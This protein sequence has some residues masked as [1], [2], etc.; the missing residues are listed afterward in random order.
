MNNCFEE[1]PTHTFL[2]ILG[3]CN[4][5]VH[6]HFAHDSRT[7]ENGSRLIDLACEKSL[8]ITNTMFQKRKGKLWTF[9]NPK[10]NR[11]QLD[12]ILVN[13]KWKNSVL[14]S[15]AYSGFAPVVSE[16]SLQKY[17]CHLE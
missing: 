11:Y 6:V 1:T 3:D 2:A 10:G 7:N 8:C 13:S 4:A 14:N 17:V 15:E 5:K 9:E 16:L 12:Y